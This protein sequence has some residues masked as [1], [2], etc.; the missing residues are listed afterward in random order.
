MADENN[1]GNHRRIWAVFVAGGFIGSS[2][3]FC[4]GKPT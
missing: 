2:L 3:T 1:S 4:L